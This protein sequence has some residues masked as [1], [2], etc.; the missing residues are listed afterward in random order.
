MNPRR[1]AASV[2]T[3]LAAGLA[4]R[5]LRGFPWALAGVVALAVAILSGMAL[6]TVAQLRDIW[7]PDRR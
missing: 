2:A 1:V 6:R 5:L 3:G 4:V 7:G